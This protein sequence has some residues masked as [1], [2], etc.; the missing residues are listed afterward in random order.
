MKHLI[1]EIASHLHAGKNVCAATIVR[2]SGSSPRA[3]GTSFMVRSDGSIVGTIGGGLL[4]AQVIQAALEALASRRT[5]RLHYRLSG[6]EVARSQMICGGDVDVFVEPLYASD[7]KAGAVYGA[8]RSAWEEG[9]RAVLATRITEGSRSS[10]EGCKI[11]LFSDG[12]Q[13]GSWDGME[14]VVRDAPDPWADVIRHAG[15]DPWVLHF[16]QNGSETD[17]LIVPIERE[18]ALYLFGGGHVSLFVAR[19]ARMVGFRVV[20]IDDREEFAHKDR[21]P[22]ADEIRVKEFSRALEGEDLDP[23]SYVVIVTRGHLYDKEVLGQILKRETVYVG[24]IGSRR[25]RDLIYRALE[26]EGISRETLHRVHSPIGLD[27]GAETPEEIAVSIVA[28][29]IGI[30][31]AREKESR[32]P[33]RGR[34]EPT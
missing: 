21:F 26:E 13:V 5:T 16:E 31:A 8:A 10:V 29:L 2:Q 15:R 33:V 1:S 11:L 3:L 24:M 22:D 7:S 23:E 19:I 9:R 27:I 20:V 32:S 6:R 14:R 18:P 34:H 30:R 4:E 28:E 17:L 12:S 25:K